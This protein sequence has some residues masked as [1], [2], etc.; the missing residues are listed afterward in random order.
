[1]S[2]AFAV[3]D[4]VATEQRATSSHQGLPSPVHACSSLCGSHHELG[5]GP[6]AQNPIPEL[7]LQACRA[8]TANLPSLL[9]L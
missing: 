8:W 5:Q 1:M 6:C 3:P 2:R 7:P 9:H 4:L